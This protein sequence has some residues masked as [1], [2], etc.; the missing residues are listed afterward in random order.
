MAERFAACKA[1]F[2]DQKRR[3]V[4]RHAHELAIMDEG[5]TAHLEHLELQYGI[6]V[7]IIGRTHRINQFR[8]GVWPPDNYSLGCF[9][10][11]TDV[12]SEFPETDTESQ[13]RRSRKSRTRSNTD[14]E[15]QV[16]RGNSEK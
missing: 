12:A 5:I 13:S 6:S 15:D 1:T 4:E 11:R 3:L 14:A 8:N 16:S 2:R 9:H 10:E 7:E